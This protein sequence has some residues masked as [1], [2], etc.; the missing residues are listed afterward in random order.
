VPHLTTTQGSIFYAQR[1][2]RQPALVCIHGAGGT[3]QHWGLQLRDLSSTVQIVAFDLP[4]H[5]RSAGPGRNSVEAYSQALLALLDE[6]KL[7]RAILAGHSMGGAVALWVALQ[8]P[9]RVAGLVLAGTGA[10]LHIM[11][12]ILDGL[13]QNPMWAIRLIMERAYDQYAIL[14]ALSAG[15]N[16]FLQIDPLTFQADLLACDSF[17]V[18]SRLGE[19]AC[20]ALVLCG[21]SDQMTPLKFSQTLHEGI[22]DAELITVPRAG[23]M[24][25]LEQP[26]VVN[27]AIRDWLTS[28]CKIG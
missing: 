8:C 3:H 4:G 13:D 14:S 1:G 27:A 21:E 19:I 2:T 16:A 25:I 12:A 6:L 11:P 9:E 5:G 7:E 24:V 28:R 22:A 10:R 23:H 18:R 15:E 17:D 20:P 26:D